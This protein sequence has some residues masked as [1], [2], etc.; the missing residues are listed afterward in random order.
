MQV[1]FLSLAL[2]TATGNSM[3]GTT[4]IKI[5]KFQGSLQGSLTFETPSALLDVVKWND[6]RPTPKLGD[7]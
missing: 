4:Q 7:L 2:M 3:S 1:P 6:H 5:V